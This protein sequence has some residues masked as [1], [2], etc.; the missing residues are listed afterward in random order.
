MTDDDF[1]TRGERACEESDVLRVMDFHWPGSW[2]RVPHGRVAE[3]H[4]NAE[5]ESLA[6]PNRPGL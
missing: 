6:S 1:V 5:Q 2:L 3:S 4:C